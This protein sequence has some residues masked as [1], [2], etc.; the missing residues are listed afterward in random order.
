[1]LRYSSASVTNLYTLY[2]KQ[3]DPR[4]I[5]YV[6]LLVYAA[7]LPSSGGSLALSLPPWDV[8]PE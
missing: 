3:L 8:E 2:S 1:M 7:N 6:F 4:R 5:V